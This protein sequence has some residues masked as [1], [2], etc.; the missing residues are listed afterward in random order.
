MTSRLFFIDHLRAALVILVVLHHLAVVYGEGESFYYVEPPNKESLTYLVLIVFVLLNQ[1]WFMGA[2][3]L[4]AGY[5]TPGSF[6]RK[7]SGSFLKNRLLRLGIP[8]IF[9]YFVLNPISMIGL[10]LEPAPR[11]GEPL[12]WNNFWQAYPYLLGMGPMWF[13][14]MLLIF[15]FVYAAW[16]RLPGNRT[17]PPTDEA[18][19]PGYLGI[20]VFI[21]TGF[22]PICAHLTI[23]LMSRTGVQLSPLAPKLVGS[24]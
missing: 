7:G 13:V 17:P 3:F 23:F 4:I 14:A 18:S 6:D 1:A 10:Y 22:G 12:T 5:F 15:S 19:P 8:L 21:L 16:R 2:L 9:F 11:I 24:F 20:G